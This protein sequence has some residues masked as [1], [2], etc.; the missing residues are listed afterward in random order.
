MPTKKPSPADALAE[1]D[2]RRSGL[3]LAD[4]PG[5]FVCS[6]E[7]SQRLGHAA[8]PS[9][10]FPYWNP[11]SGEFTPLD[12]FHR[13]R[14]LSPPGG[15]TAQT[16]AQR[17]SQ[18]AGSLND[19]YVPRRVAGADFDWAGYLSDPKR[20]ALYFTE[21]EKKALAG[22]KA[23]LPVIALGGVTVWCAQTR[24]AAELPMLSKIDFRGRD[25]YVV[26]DTDEDAG[27]KPEVLT[28]AHRFMEHLLLRG[29]TPSLVVLPSDGGKTGLDDYLLSHSLDDLYAYVDGHATAVSDSKHLCECAARYAYVCSVDRFV[30]L[31][32][33]DDVDYMTVDHADHVLGKRE[34]VLPRLERVRV[35]G[36]ASVVRRQPKVMRLAD[37][38]LAWGGADKFSSA[39][40]RPGSPRVV[41]E[42]RAHM[43]NLWTGWRCEY[44]DSTLPTTEQRQDALGEWE[45]ALDN[46]FGC[47]PVAREYVD[48]W[49]YYPMRHPGAKLY[50]CALVCSREQGVGKSFIG[51]ML[52]KHVYGLAR[53]GPRHAWQLSEGDLHGQ[54]N[55]YMHAVSFVEADDIAAS[56]KKSVYERVKSFVTSDTVQVN[57]KGVPQFMEVN[58]ANFWFT[59]ND[60]APFFLSQQDRRAFVHV[61][62]RAKK[63][64]AR[65]RALE[66]MFDRGVAGPSLLWHARERYAEG[67]FNP[68][69]AAPMTAGRADV[70]LN[71]R[72]ALRD[73]ACCLVDGAETLTRP[74]ATGR[75]VFALMQLEVPGG[76]RYSADAV[77]HALRDAGAGRWR[78][79]QQVYVKTEAGARR[80]ERVWLLGPAGA[81][82]SKDDLAAGLAGAAFNRRSAGDNVVPFP[83]ATKPKAP[84]AKKF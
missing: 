3:T 12:Q 43:L 4:C 65:Y 59:S 27:L 26:F 49:L 39:V 18:P 54:F 82:L 40:Y 35:Q 32:A 48:H 69:A 81:A 34:V 16:K 38:M 46:V 66:L 75:E 80:A 50:T 53:P 2:L 31:S 23:G 74:Y 17:Y 77:G 70:L 72:S 44:S 21:G 47:D 24:G 25:A 51:H 30:P 71:G 10:A 56:E 45:W 9:V 20:G 8:L 13:A 57:L 68:R 5:A 33:D 7:E 52:A 58:C 73:W 36:G 29:A 78:D 62:R 28:A 6:A 11:F 55:P 84:G 67:A 64:E 1:A 42:G 76:E 15:F 41:D 37:A 63:D 61:P 79:G 14:Y 83:K 60:D 19:L 22:A